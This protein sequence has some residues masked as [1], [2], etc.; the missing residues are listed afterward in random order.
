MSTISKDYSGALRTGINTVLSSKITIGA[1]TYKFFKDI[2]SVG[3]NKTYVT[4]GPIIDTEAGSKEQFIY[5]GSISVETVDMSQT[6][7]PK[8][9]LSETVNNKV[10]GLLKATKGATFTVTG[11]TLIYFR[12]GGSTRLEEKLKDGRT[13]F[14]IIDIYEFLI[15]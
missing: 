9:T 8:R 15:Q 11:F 13:S 4:L 14:R 5:Q 10:R 1:V 6:M 3:P 7:N 12:H 2:E